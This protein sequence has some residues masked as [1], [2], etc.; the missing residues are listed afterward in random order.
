M[1][2]PP[3]PG[4][5]RWRFL[6]SVCHYWEVIVFLLTESVGARYTPVVRIQWYWF[7][8]LGCKTCLSLTAQSWSPRGGRSTGVIPL[9]NALFLCFSISVEVRTLCPSYES[10]CGALKGLFGERVAV[11]MVNLVD[12]SLW[13]QL[14][15]PM[16]LWKS[17]FFFCQTSSILK[18]D[19]TIKCRKRLILHNIKYNLFEGHLV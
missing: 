12:E 17:S 13:Q 6:S 9:R 3:P 18:A 10:I 16:P 5:A 19:W 8:T 2:V 7:F 14:R 11:E 15:P 1:T 4:Q